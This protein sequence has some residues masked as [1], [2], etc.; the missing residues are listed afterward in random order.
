LDKRVS[1]NCFLLAFFCSFLD[2]LFNN[3]LLPH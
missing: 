3:A 1:L 2:E